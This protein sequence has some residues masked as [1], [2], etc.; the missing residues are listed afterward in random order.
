[1]HSGGLL[2]A[3]PHAVRGAEGREAAGVGRNT[4]AVFMQPMWDEPMDPPAPPAGASG[5]H[6]PAGGGVAGWEPGQDFGGFTA[7]KIT[8]YY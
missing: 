5:E 8:Q 7:R 4:F 1:M 3:T 6:W 2:Q